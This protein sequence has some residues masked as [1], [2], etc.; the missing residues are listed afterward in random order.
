[1]IAETLA[2]AL[3]D[4]GLGEFEKNIF[5][6]RMP[7]DDIGQDGFW[8]VTQLPGGAPTGGNVSSWKTLTQLQVR[9][10]FNSEDGDK[11]YELDTTVRRALTELPYT[12]DRFAR[13]T[14]EPMGDDDLT[15]AEQRSGIWNVTT[16]TI[17]DNMENS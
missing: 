16:I 5:V 14:V 11:L 4:A 8:C 3:A 10:V 9:A 1:M 17:N 15:V 13:V 6:G 2:L 7:A 12:D